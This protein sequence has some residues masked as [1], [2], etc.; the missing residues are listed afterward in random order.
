MARTV[1]IFSEPRHPSRVCVAPRLAGTGV[2]RR[3]TAKL[4]SPGATCPP[5]SCLSA[6]PCRSPA[7]PGLGL[8]PRKRVPRPHPPDWVMPGAVSR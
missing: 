5:G 2:L 1:F 4:A 3:R 8:L 7:P 6:P